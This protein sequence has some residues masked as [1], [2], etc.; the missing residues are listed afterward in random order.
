MQRGGPDSVSAAQARRILLGEQLGRIEVTSR[1]TVAD[2][3]ARHL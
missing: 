1:G 3:L 2:E